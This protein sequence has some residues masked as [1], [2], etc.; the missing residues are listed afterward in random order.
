MAHRTN[1]RRVLRSRIENA[2]LLNSIE[3]AR[4]VQLVDTSN[5]VAGKSNNGGCYAF[6][7]EFSPCVCGCGKLVKE[8]YTSAEFSYC[9]V[10]GGFK[11]CQGCSYN[12]PVHG[13]QKGFELYEKTQLVGII[14]DWCKK[15]ETDHFVNFV[16]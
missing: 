8:Y 6:S 7:E 16:V 1:R 11:T 5:F 15:S 12:D 13:C 10:E 4:F 2:N 3:N 14:R 9:V